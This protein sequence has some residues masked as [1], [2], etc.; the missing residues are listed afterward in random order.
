MQ[1]FL[2]KAHLYLGCIFVPLLLFFTVT[3]FLQTFQ[4]HKDLKNGSYQAPQVLKEISEVHKKQRMGERDKE[5]PTR[6]LSFRYLVALMSV[7]VSGTI[8]LGVI[9]AF[10]TLRSP[11]PVILCLVAGT[12]LPALLLLLGPY[13]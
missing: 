11:G 5:K 13:V 1:R 3:G 10:Q 9:M 6:S 2:R 4:F 12:V 7:G 8:V